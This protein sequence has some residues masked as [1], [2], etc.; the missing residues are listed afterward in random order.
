MLTSLCDPDYLMSG[1]DITCPEPRSA[2]VHEMTQVEKTTEKTSQRT[3]E[4]GSFMAS[5]GREK[6]AGRLARKRKSSSDAAEILKDNRS[7]R[8]RRM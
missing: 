4:R 1:A 6:V 2:F 3:R 5:S 8:E 7:R